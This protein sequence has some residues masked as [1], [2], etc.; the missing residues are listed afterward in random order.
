MNPVIWAALI[1]AT[2]GIVGIFLSFKKNKALAEHTTGLNERKEKRERIVKAVEEVHAT[3]KE[4][5]DALDDLLKNAP[6]PNDP[7]NIERS[8]VCRKKREE[9]E[10][11]LELKK[12]YL[13]SDI[14]KKA[15]EVSIAISRVDI[16]HR[17]AREMRGT[18]DGKA[19]HED[20]HQAQEILRSQMQSL[21]REFQKLIL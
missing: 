8:N 3:L 18:P 14:V 13:P 17:M 19:R 2:A 11:S 7:M 9:F 1:A 4:Q 15:K 6:P 10:K 16:A 20:L 5:E 12:L 21:E